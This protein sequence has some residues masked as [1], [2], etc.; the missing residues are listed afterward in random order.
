MLVDLA[1]LNVMTLTFTLPVVTAGASLTAMNYVLFHLHR[2]DETYITK[3]FRKSFKDNLKQGIP[4]GLLA[5]LIAAVVAADLWFFHGQ[6][7]RMATMMMIVISVISTY[8]IAVFIYMFALQSRYDNSVWGTIQNA[9]RLSLAN[10]PRTALMMITW[11]IWAA[12]LIYLH[13][14][15]S[16]AFLLYGLTLPG[17]IC[18]I[19]YEPIFTRLEGDEESE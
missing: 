17:F 14:A 13:N 6:S 15:A 16:V 18:T 2:G 19:L 9:V 4:E 12:I 7:S 5:M 11:L 10:L 8:I 1:V 3:M